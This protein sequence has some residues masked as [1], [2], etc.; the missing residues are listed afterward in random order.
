M[1]CDIKEP[2]IMVASGDFYAEPRVVLIDFGLSASFLG[3]SRGVCGTPGYIPPETWQTG[4]WHPRG[5]TFS[6]GVTFFQLMTGR[7]P[8]S[9]GSVVGVLQVPINGDYGAAAFHTPLPWDEFPQTM[10]QLADL[11]DHMTDRRRGER[12]IPA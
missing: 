12:P 9:D 2:N 7:V 6:M 4:I 10:T 5:D 1:H 3:G 8:S 11:I